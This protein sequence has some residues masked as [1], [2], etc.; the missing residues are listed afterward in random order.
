[1]AK[2]S[3]GRFITPALARGIRL[4]IRPVECHGCSTPDLDVR[5]PGWPAPQRFT[6]VRP[7][8]TAVVALAD[9]PGDY[10]LRELDTH[11]TVKREG[12]ALYLEIG[13]GVQPSQVL[14]LTPLGRDAFSGRSDDPERFDL[15]AL[16]R[17]SVTFRRDPSGRVTGLRFTMD[18]VRNLDLPRVR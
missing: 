13:A 7:A 16:G 6:R 5:Q 8:D 12:G 2:A 17:V 11:Y 9:Y 1:V 10:L 18:R 4:E 3:D 15:F 14:R